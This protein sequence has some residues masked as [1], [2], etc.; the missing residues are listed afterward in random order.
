MF[1]Q[2]ITLLRPHHWVKNLLIFFPILLSPKEF[3]NIGTIS[4]IYVF[5]C[6]CLVASGIYIFNDIKDAKKDRINTRT[7]NRPFAQGTIT[8]SKGYSL[9]L[10][11]MTVAFVISITLVPEALSLL[12]LYVVINIFYTL[13]FKYI[14]I[15]INFVYYS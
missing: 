3:T 4:S 5:I 15:F 11:L 7:K 2:Y 9:S 10:I 14:V 13:Y 1:T 8:I 6:F 12:L